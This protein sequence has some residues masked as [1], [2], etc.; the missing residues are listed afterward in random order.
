MLCVV[1]RLHPEPTQV[2]SETRSRKKAFLNQMLKTAALLL[3]FSLP[4]Q[5]SLV[6]AHDSSFTLNFQ[7]L[8]RSRPNSLRRC[9]SLTSDLSLASSIDEI[10]VLSQST[11]PAYISAHCNRY[12]YLLSVH[13]NQ[14]PPLRSGDDTATTLSMPRVYTRLQTQLYPDMQF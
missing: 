3:I 6:T 12:P 5:S 7:G 1:L 4:M 9:T 8:Q 14:A 13:S 10:S 11:G 2:D